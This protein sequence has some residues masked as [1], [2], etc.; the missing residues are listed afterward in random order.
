MKVCSPY[1]TKNTTLSD[2]VLVCI[3]FI[4]IFCFLFDF[5]P[6]SQG[7]AE[8][9]KSHKWFRSV[10]WDVVPQRQLKVFFCI[11]IQQL[12][13]YWHLHNEQKSE[14]FCWIQLD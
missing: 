14:D 10:D 12:Q 4:I 3:L 8:D 1:T 5:Y 7:G 2:F 13:H 9:V 11:C 6:V